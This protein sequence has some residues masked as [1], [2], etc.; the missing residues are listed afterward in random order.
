MQ[1]KYD[2]QNYFLAV[3]IFFSTRDED[4][5]LK[6]KVILRKVNLHLQYFKIYLS[7]INR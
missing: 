7:Y 2:K 6:V 4:V 1:T 5:F 3:T